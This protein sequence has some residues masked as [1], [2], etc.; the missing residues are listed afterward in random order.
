MRHLEFNGAGPLGGARVT[1]PDT[2]LAVVLIH[3][4]P[5]GDPCAGMILAGPNGEDL[6]A[7]DIVDA[8]HDLADQLHD[9]TE[10][11]PDE[12]D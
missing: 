3:A 12:H 10:G 2:T 1:V 9:A 4:D 6:D 8:L 5:D 11:A 7:S